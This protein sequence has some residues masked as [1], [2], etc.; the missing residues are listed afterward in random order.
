MASAGHSRRMQYATPKAAVSTFCVA[1]TRSA[2]AIDTPHREAYLVRRGLHVTIV[3]GATGRV[4]DKAAAREQIV[5]S[6]ASFSRAPVALAV[7]VDSP[8]RPGDEIT[9][10]AQFMGGS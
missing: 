7:R 1:V 6:L 10:L 3:P 4:L 8:L 2:K 5:D 9:L